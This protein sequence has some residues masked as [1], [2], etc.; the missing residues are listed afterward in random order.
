MKMHVEEK[1]FISLAK[2]TV[3]KCLFKN[4]Y[5]RKWF[6]EIIVDQAGINLSGYQL[7]D[8][9]HNTGSKIK[10]IDWIYY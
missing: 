4:E 3:F 10:I 9:E 7:I 6:E 2:D 8:G 1:Q 5:F